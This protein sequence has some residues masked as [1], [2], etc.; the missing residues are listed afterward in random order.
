MGQL[1]ISDLLFF[2]MRQSASDDSLTG[3]P[4]SRL[5][6]RLVHLVAQRIEVAICS[7]KIA[8][9]NQ[10][11]SLSL[12]ANALSV[13]QSWSSSKTRNQSADF[14]RQELIKRFMTRATGFVNGPKHS[15]NSDLVE[16]GSAGAKDAGAGLAAASQLCTAYFAKASECLFQKIAG[17]TFRHLAYYHD[18]AKVSTY[19]VPCHQVMARI[20]PGYLVR[21]IYF[22]HKTCECVQ[23]TS[24]DSC[25]FYRY[26]YAPEHVCVLNY[27]YLTYAETLLH[28]LIGSM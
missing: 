25:G 21:T 6:K 24:T 12:S 22:I 20:G 27:L 16:S 15:N 23:Y 19:D 7:G 17:Q 10:P 26:M 1:Y 8:V 4:W 28:S 13:K 3:I 18:S 5:Q 11:P 2:F 9:S 14:F